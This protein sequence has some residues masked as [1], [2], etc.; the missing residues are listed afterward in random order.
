M[1]KLKPAEKWELKALFYLS[2]LD[3]AIIGLFQQNPKFRQQAQALGISVRLVVHKRE[4]SKAWDFSGEEARP[5]SLEDP[6]Q[7]TLQFESHRLF[8]Q[9]IEEKTSPFAAIL[10][11]RLSVKG[12]VTQAYAFA[13]LLSQ[14]G[15][16]LALLKNP[17]RE[18][19]EEDG[20]L[21]RL[22]LVYALFTVFS[23]WLALKEKQ[24]P[25]PTWNFY[26]KR[27]DESVW[28]RH[29]DGE[30]Q[31]GFDPG[32][33]EWPLRA[34]WRISSSADLKRA[35]D[36]PVLLVVYLFTGKLSIRGFRHTVAWVKHFLPF[37]NEVGPLLT[38]GEEEKKPDAPSGKQ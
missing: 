12:S 5:L 33:P 31:T 6:V 10:L 7:L 38:G 4:S 32:H 23:V 9:V 27:E 14:A 29:A 18:G 11:G 22:S 26:F 1:E 21:A 2:L 8:V 28:I 13:R 15:Q 37:I 17:E 36:K 3:R 35:L 30:I 34:S 19:E 20:K 16:V 25:Q 24:P